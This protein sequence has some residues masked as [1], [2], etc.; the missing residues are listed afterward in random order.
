MT[1]VVE[2]IETFHDDRMLAFEKADFVARMWDRHGG[3]LL[4]VD[5]DVM[6]QGRPTLPVQTGCD[7]AVHK[8][9]GWEMSAR[10]LYFGGS[11]AGGSMLRCW[12]QLASS[13][14]D[15]WDGYLLDQAWSLTSSQMPLD[16]V[17]LP[18]SYHAVAGDVGA[19]RATIVHNLKPTTAD[20]G[21]DPDFADAA[22]PAR[23][24]GRTGARESLIVLSSKGASYK[25]VTVILR[26]FEGSGAR[27]T[28]ASI[29]AVTSAFA[30]DCGG[31][32]RLELSLCPWQDEVRVAKEAA[33]LADNSVIE[34][35][36]LQDLP[37][38]L[39]RSLAT[40]QAAHQPGIVT[41]YRR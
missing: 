18:R 5:A 23:R 38:D 20:L 3:P 12:Q 24:A 26:D 28:A 6:L 33:F 27:A 16:T 29:E 7:F 10:A 34:I 17:W 1:F 21:P 13:Y 39:F 41:G 37:R 11:E 32:S 19:K 8:W 15:I 4:F 35:V 25:A 31:F 30:A 40:S 2:P 14:A 9:N 22:R 36:P